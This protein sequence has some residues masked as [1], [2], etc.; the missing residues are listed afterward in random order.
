MRERGVGE[1]ERETWSLERDKVQV[2]CP[3]DFNDYG[4]SVGVF[5]CLCI[6]SGHDIM[7]V[8]I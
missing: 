5:V 7:L 8:F 4:C 6:L 1:G 3:M 2:E